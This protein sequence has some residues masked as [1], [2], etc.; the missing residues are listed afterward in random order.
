MDISSSRSAS[1][2]SS[3]RSTGCATPASSLFW[4]TA[5]SRK[6]GIELEFCGAKA[7]FPTGAVDLALRTNA[8]LLTGWVR[9][10]G[11]YKIHVDVTPLPLVVTGNRDEDVRLNTARLL[12]SFEKHLKED[13]GQW[14][15]LDRIWPDEPARIAR[16][17]GRGHGRRRHQRGS[18]MSP[19]EA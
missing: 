15:V 11:G 19:V 6:R 10:E 4:S 16:A 18:T 2:R 14:S 13:P 8:V 5:I 1:L 3:T 7:R 12:A 17:V 9:R